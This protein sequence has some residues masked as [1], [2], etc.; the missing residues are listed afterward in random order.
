MLAACDLCVDDFL[1]LCC[2]VGQ[3][4]LGE[5]RLACLDCGQNRVL[6]ELTRGGYYDCINFRIVDQCVCIGV[7][8]C[9]SANQLVGSL[10]TRLE[11]VTDCYNRRA[12]NL[13]LQTLCVLLADHTATDDTYSQFHNTYL[14]SIFLF[15]VHGVLFSPP[16]PLWIS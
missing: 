4:L 10:C 12:L 1:A 5:Y 16:C 15:R 13:I 7:N 3:R 8:L 2:G 11:Y 9:I 6:V 14:H